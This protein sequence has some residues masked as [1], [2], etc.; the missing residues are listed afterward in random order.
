MS[1]TTDIYMGVLFG[2]KLGSIYQ[3]NTNHKPNK[4]KVKK[5][6]QHS[7]DDASREGPIYFKPIYIYIYTHI[8][9]N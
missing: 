6:N 3:F 2:R 4:K 8:Y 7:A 5:I 1:H 9:E